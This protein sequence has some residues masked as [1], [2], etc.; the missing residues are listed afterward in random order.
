MIIKTDNS[1]FK[2]IQIPRQEFEEIKKET[3]LFFH[4][5]YAPLSLMSEQADER[6]GYALFDCDGH[7]L[8]LY[9]SEAFLSFCNNI[10]ILRGTRW[11]GE[12][13]GFNA[14][15]KGLNEN[16]PCVSE[17]GEHMAPELRLINIYFWP[18]SLDTE[19]IKYSFA[20]IPNTELH[21]EGNDHGKGYNIGLCGGVA[22][23]TVAEEKSHLYLPLVE[24]TARE[25]NL[26]LYWHIVASRDTIHNSGFISL[27]QTSGNNK[28]MILS[29]GI[30]EVLNLP[31]R[32]Y[33][34]HPLNE[35]IDPPPDNREL[36]NILKE[37]KIVLEYPLVITSRGCP[38]NTKI[39]TRRSIEKTFRI[40]EMVLWI[41]RAAALQ[42]SAIAKDLTAKA[43]FEDIIAKN[44]GYIEILNRAKISSLS[45][46]NILLLGESGTGKDIIAQAIHNASPRKE[47]PFIAVNC[48]SFSKDLIA[49]DL[50]GY[51]AGAFTGASKSGAIGKFQMADKGTLF[52]DEIGDMPLELQSNLLRA[53]EQKSFMQVGGTQEI[54]VDVRIISA[55]NR[56]LKELIEKGLFRMDLYYRLGVGKLVIPPL[57]QR[58][59]D[60]LPLAYYFLFNLR[61]RYNRSA[62]ILSP[63]AE[64]LF[65]N[66]SWPGNV[67]ELQNLLEGIVSISS[68]PMIKPEHIYSY[69]EQEDDGDYYTGLKTDKN[70]AARLLVEKEEQS[71]KNTG[72]ANKRKLNLRPPLVEK[73]CI[74][75]ALHDNNYNCTRAAK[76]LKI[77][78]RTLYRRMEQYNLLK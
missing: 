64:E 7:L 1:S 13:A 75:A 2:L 12:K 14:V 76:E 31:V 17:A 66:Y 53:I 39:S 24:A 16:L 44:P 20:Q 30:Y 33:H 77:S 62:I 49:S 38:I 35:V 43:S 58:K 57:R 70:S 5:A 78:R 71:G 40:H 45:D 3:K 34:L 21:L 56:H 9:G 60:I 25:I 18:V 69:L 59:D 65:L 61:I 47:Y 46:C 8:R 23:L 22:I 54:K 55:T 6:W 27:D 50:F 4:C 72:D 37:R 10:G 36:W 29:S 68:S 52:L 48:A 28:I 74:V 15:S 41:Q 32:D 63:E 11:S 19:S 26:Q 51:A 73:E 42:K 67:R